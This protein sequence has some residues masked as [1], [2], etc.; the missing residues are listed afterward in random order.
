MDCPP[1]RGLGLLVGGRGVPT[2]LTPFV[3]PS[4]HAALRKCALD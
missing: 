4:M 3:R 2:S 1:R